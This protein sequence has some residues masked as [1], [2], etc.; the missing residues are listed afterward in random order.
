M[1][2]T[3]SY[4]FEKTKWTNFQLDSPRKKRGAQI[5]K[6]RN[7]RE[8]TTDTTETQRIIR[9]CYEPVYTNKLDNLEDMDEFLETYNLPGRNHEEIG[10]LIRL[11]TRSLG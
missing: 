3:K 6:I 9:D 10:N 7:K 11:I 2:E 8:V 4:F 5:N 1:S